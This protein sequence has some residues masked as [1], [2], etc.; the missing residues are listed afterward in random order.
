MSLAT[1]MHRAAPNAYRVLILDNEVT[2][3]H[4]VAD[5]PLSWIRLTR[6]DGSYRPSEGYPTL[7]TEA[8]ARFEM[9][10]WDEVSVGGIADALQEI[11]D[12]AH[13][14]IIGNN[15]GQGLPLAMNLP[16][17]VIG[18]AAIIYARNL[19][20][21]REYYKIGYR[22]FFPRSESVAHLTRLAEG[23]SLDPALFFINTIQHNELNYHTP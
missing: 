23:A 3:A 4:F 10:N 17:E 7:L 2:V 16:Q 8:Q 22:T 6:Q 5:P 15:A 9:R 18:R 1:E 12:G 13:Y 21:E 14:V 11:S 19:P 20:E